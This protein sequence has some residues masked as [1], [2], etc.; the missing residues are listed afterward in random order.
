MKDNSESRTIRTEYGPI[1]VDSWL[2]DIWAKYGW[3]TEETLAA[4]AADQ[5]D[6]RARDRNYRVYRVYRVRHLDNARESDG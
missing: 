4:M 6:A 3:P 1:V 5:R 2:L